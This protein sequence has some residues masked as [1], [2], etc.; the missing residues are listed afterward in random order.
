MD[1]LVFGNAFNTVSTYVFSPD[2]IQITSYTVKL[3]ETPS[4]IFVLFVYLYNL[5]YH[6]APKI[7]MVPG[8]KKNPEKIRTNE[9]IQITQVTTIINTEFTDS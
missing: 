1:C 3:K 2:I 9:I 4:I 7:V 8:N 5:Y 6:Q